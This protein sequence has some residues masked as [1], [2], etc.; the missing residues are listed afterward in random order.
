MLT[1]VAVDESAGGIARHRARPRAEDADRPQ[2]PPR[3]HARAGGR[4]LLLRRLRRLRRRH[5]P[6]ARQHAAARADR[7]ERVDRSLGRSRQSRP[8][9]TRRCLDAEHASQRDRLDVRA[10]SR[11]CSMRRTTSRSA[12]SRRTT[13]SRKLRRCSR[14]TARAGMVRPLRQRSRRARRHHVRV[15]NCCIRA[16]SSTRAGCNRCAASPRTSSGR[17]CSRRGRESLLAAGCTRRVDRE[18]HCATRAPCRTISSSR[19]P[20]GGSSVI[21]GNVELRVPLMKQFERR[22]FVDGAYVGTGGLATLGARGKGAVTPGIGFR[23]RSPLGVIRLDFGLRPVGHELLPVVVAVPDSC[24]RGSASCGSRR[25][26]RT[27][28]SRILRRALALDRA[29]DRRAL[30]DGTGVLMAQP[31]P[32][33]GT[34]WRPT[35]RRRHGG[36]AW[37]GRCSSW[38]CCRSCWDSR[39]C[40]CSRSRRGVTSVCGAC[41]SRRRMGACTG[42][43]DVGTLRGN[44]FSGATLTDVRLV[45]SARR[46]LFTARRVQV[47]LRAAAGA[48]RPHRVRS[49]ALD[50][51]EVLLD[52]RPARAGTSRR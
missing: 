5:D 36:A 29:P 23:Y 14:F 30:R 6:G 13:A 4:S 7:R 35:Q 49:L 27:R 39:S 25:R 31:I 47:R 41:S 12:R 24:G 15:R 37:C 45:D 3:G 17:A 2:L 8:A 1:G 38:W 32:R 46:P 48:A 18:R 43:L 26:S 22:A 52:K 42:S 9:A 51:A 33:E 28:R 19:R 11:R 10:Q 50:T 44:L 21:E 16:R 20:T 40:C 34:P